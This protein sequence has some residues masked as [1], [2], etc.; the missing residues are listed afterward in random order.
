MKT[1]Q[2]EKAALDKQ[3][4]QFIFATSTAFSAV[5]HPELIK[6][7]QLLRPGYNPPS[8]HAVGGT[9]FNEVQQSLMDDC[10]EKLQKKTVSMCLDG[11]SNVHN[12]PIVCVAVTTPDG[13]S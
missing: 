7:V 10:K 3:V 12:E 13:D 4:V 5:E 9:L 2:S 6:I 1:S 8:C 11:W